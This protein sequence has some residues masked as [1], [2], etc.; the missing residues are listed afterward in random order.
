MPLAVVTQKGSRSGIV[1]TIALRAGTGIIIGADNRHR[2]AVVVSIGIIGI[3]VG[4]V[5][6]IPRAAVI[7]VGAERAADDRT[8]RQT[9]PEPAAAVT[10]SATVPAAGTAATCRR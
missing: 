6:I 4:T 5:V 2:S 7:R 8:G 1:G 9:R 10:P 3:V